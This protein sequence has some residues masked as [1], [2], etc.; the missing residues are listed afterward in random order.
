[1]KI[2]LKKLL[3]CLGIPL[4]VGGLAALLSGSFS[5]QYS[6]FTQP[7]LAP[8]GWVFPVVWTVLYLLMGWASYRIVVAP[9]SRQEK[10]LPLVLYGLQLAVN[11]LWPILFFRYGL[12]LSAFFLLIALWILILL[13]IRFFSRIDER[14]G[15]LLLPYILWV[16][17]AGYLN[18]GVFLLN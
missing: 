16:T 14:A 2:D 3:L 4:T 11:F 13:T 8:P 17:F 9:V 6:Q 10:V 18:L 1:M 15:D 12:F 7:P 5:E